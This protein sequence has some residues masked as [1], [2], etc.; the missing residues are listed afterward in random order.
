MEALYVHFSHPTKN[1]KLTDLQFKLNMKKITL[2]QLSDTRWVCRYKSCDAVITNFNVIVQVLNDEIDDQ[3]SKCVA[4]AIGL[5]CKITIG[6]N[7]FI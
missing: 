4:Q 6:F 2:S 3:Q 1:L 5:L 7:V